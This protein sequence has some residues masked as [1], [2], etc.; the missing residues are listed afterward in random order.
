MGQ[1]PESLVQNQPW[2]MAVSLYSQG[3]ASA[4]DTKLQG[5]PH[6]NKLRTSGEFSLFSGQ[7]EGICQ[8]LAPA[9]Q[10]DSLMC[11]RFWKLTVQ[12]KS[13]ASK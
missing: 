5:V 12:S 9:P 3:P 10:L 13:Q 11:S 1:G 2:C 8:V 4:Y 7:L 6:R